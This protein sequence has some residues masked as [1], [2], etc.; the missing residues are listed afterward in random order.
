MNIPQIIILASGCLALLAAFVFYFKANN[1]AGTIT[2]TVA[3]LMSLV[4][5]VGPATIKDMMFKQS[6]AG[7]EFSFRR[8]IDTPEKIQL[9]I[10][11]DSE[12]DKGNTSDKSVK[13]IQETKDTPDSKRSAADYLILATDNW[14]SG[15]YIEG[16]AFA[17]QGLMLDPKDVRLKATLLHRMGALLADM[18]VK[19]KAEEFYYKSIGVDSKFSWPYNNL[20]PQQS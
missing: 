16:M 20:V 8:N 10:N 15:N 4:G 7:F 13:L 14:K 6:N 11:V 2:I 19:V 17:Q 1:V 5:G 3:F 9:A 18:G 12:I